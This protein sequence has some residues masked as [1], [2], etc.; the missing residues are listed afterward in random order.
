MLITNAYVDRNLAGSLNAYL[1]SQTADEVMTEHADFGEY[2][3]PVANLYLDLVDGSLPCVK[4][5]KWRSGSSG[6]WSNDNYKTRY[7]RN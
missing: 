4:V 7:S 2:P 6:E 5:S 1:Y 3:T